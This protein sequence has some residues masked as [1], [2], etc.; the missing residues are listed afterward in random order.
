MS[1]KTNI[2]FEENLLTNFEE[3]IKN[4]QAVIIK[5]TNEL[6]IT[7][8]AVLRE[9]GTHLKE[10][11]INENGDK[12]LSRTYIKNGKGVLDIITSQNLE[13]IRNIDNVDEQ[14]SVL[15]ESGN[16]MEFSQIEYD[17]TMAIIKTAKEG[18][19]ID[20]LVQEYSI[21]FD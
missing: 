11:I 1:E 4:G 14:L 7:E 17:S 10:Q 3:A 20:E 8:K 21:M 19:D 16:P 2:F 6:G 5:T 9:C 13:T 12:I 15:E 18:K